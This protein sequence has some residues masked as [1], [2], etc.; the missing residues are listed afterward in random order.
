MSDAAGGRRRDRRERRDLAP[1]GPCKAHAHPC[2][3]PPPPPAFLNVCEFFQNLTGIYNAPSRG[4]LGMDALRRHQ[5]SLELSLRRSLLAED[6]TDD[7]A[8]AC[9]SLRVQARARFSCRA[10]A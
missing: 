8:R 5:Q 10:W 2:Y 9:R 4:L 6:L 7:P 3:P 1:H